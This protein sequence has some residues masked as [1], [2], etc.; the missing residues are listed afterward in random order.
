MIL[1]S[2]KS[3]IFVIFP[4]ISIISSKR[5]PLK[6]KAS[7]SNVLET[8]LPLEEND[9]FSKSKGNYLFDENLVIYR[10]KE[11][12]IGKDKNESNEDCSESTEKLKSTTSTEYDEFKDY[13]TTIPE[14]ISGRKTH[15]D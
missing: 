5:I 9:E 2:L 7:I 13:E 3:I 1:I 4:L 12:I 6:R 10:K 14:H 8:F 11:K 15:R